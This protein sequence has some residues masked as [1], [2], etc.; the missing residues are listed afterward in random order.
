[1]SYRETGWYVTGRDAAGNPNNVRYWNS[2]HQQWSAPAW[3]DDN[4]ERLAKVQATPGESTPAYVGERWPSPWVR[5]SEEVLRSNEEVSKALDKH[6]ELVHDIERI[7]TKQGDSAFLRGLATAL[8]YNENSSAV[9]K[10]RLDEIAMRISSGYYGVPATLEEAADV[11]L[12][13]RL[14]SGMLAAEAWKSR[15][16]EIKTHADGSVVL[17]VHPA[18]P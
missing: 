16:V 15:C 11:S 1:M 4:A 2:Q 5:L 6:V 17:I 9:E 18:K 12:V 13:E 3:V 14:W 10:H 7:R 8:S